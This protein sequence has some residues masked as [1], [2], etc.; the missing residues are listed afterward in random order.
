MMENI[1]KRDRLSLL[2]IVLIVLWISHL[3]YLGKI[4]LHADQNIQELSKNASELAENLKRELGF[5]GMTQSD[6]EKR[7]V[8][9]FRILFIKTLLLYSAGILSGILILKK[10]RSGR[11]IA[12]GL[13]SYFLIF[14]IYD[15]LRHGRIW[16]RL[17]AKYTILF[18]AHPIRVIH[19]DIL[20]AII[21]VITIIYLTRPSVAKLFGKNQN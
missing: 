2:G 5:G 12:I 19:T 9:S 18:P 6:I 11:F 15:L 21:G 20:P 14:Q 3:P 1:N 17:Y 16:Q 13:F 10:H 8:Q 7:A 4:P